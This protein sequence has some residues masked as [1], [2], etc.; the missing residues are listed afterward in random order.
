[1]LR[2][3]FVIPVITHGFAHLS[4]FLAAFTDAD[5]GYT[6]NPWVFSGHVTL[7]QWPGRAFGLMWLLS[8]VG[9]VSS[10]VGIL[11][12]Q[13]WWPELLVGSSALSLV[14]ILPWIKSVPPGAIAGAV[15]DVLVLTALLSPLKAHLIAILV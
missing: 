9:L 7:R 1:M 11:F 5:V 10:G 4:G 2:Y 14:T 13:P 6:K 8:T 3:L 15:F 12:G